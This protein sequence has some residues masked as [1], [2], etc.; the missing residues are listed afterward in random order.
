MPVYDLKDIQQSLSILC[1]VHLIDW[2]LNLIWASITVKYHMPDRL[3]MHSASSKLQAG[4]ITTTA[5]IGVIL[6]IA[7]I[8]YHCNLLHPKCAPKIV[9]N[10]DGSDIQE[11]H[12]FTGHARHIHWGCK[13]TCSSGAQSTAWTHQLDIA[14][15]FCF[16]YLCFHDCLTWLSVIVGLKDPKRICSCNKWRSALSQSHWHALPAKHT[17]ARSGSIALPGGAIST[18][19]PLHVIWGAWRHAQYDHQ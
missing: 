15:G 12:S 16:A 1:M 19:P 10:W 3:Q 14:A 7:H 2:L 5:C 4:L 6:N 17:L 11:C 13:V 9:K 8:V 18:S